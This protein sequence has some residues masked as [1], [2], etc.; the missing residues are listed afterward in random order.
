MISLWTLFLTTKAV[1]LHPFSVHHI[2]KSLTLV[3]TKGEP[4]VSSSHI[5]SCDQALIFLEIIELFSVSI[6]SI[7]PS[8]LKGL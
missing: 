3:I 7:A 4:N 6:T 5:S 2:K 8:S 1:A